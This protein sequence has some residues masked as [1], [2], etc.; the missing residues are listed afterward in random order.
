MAFNKT[1]FLLIIEWKCCPELIVLVAQQ[2]SRIDKAEVLL[3]AKLVSTKCIP[4]ILS[5]HLGDRF[6]CP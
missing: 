6:V 3:E 2:S 1:L 5:K 4:T